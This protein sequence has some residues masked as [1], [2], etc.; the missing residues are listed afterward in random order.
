M[1]PYNSGH[2]IY[3]NMNNTL[4]ANLTVDNFAS[5]QHGK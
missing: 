5:L 1:Y 2:L 3:Y 4:K